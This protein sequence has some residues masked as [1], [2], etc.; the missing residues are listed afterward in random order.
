MT[1]KHLAATETMIVTRDRLT[2]HDTCVTVANG[3]IVSQTISPRAP[4]QDISK[5]TLAERHALGMRITGLPS[6]NA[7]PHVCA[8]APGIRTYKDIPPVVAGGRLFVKT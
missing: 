6:I 4:R 7:I 8:A 2:D 3:K 5:M 1:V